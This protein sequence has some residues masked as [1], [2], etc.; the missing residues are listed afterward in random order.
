[1][2][3][4]GDFNGRVSN[5]LARDYIEQD[6][7]NESLDSARYVPDTP[8]L[9]ASVDNVS[10]NHGLQ[11]LDLCKST[12]LRIA[13]GRTDSGK[14]FTYFCRTGSSVID[15]LLLKQDNFGCICD[16][17][18]LEFNE[19]SDHA[20][21]QFALNIGQEK[22]KENKHPS[23]AYS[24]KF[25]WVPEKNIFRRKLIAKLPEINGVFGNID[26]NSAECVNETVLSFVNI[27]NEVAEPCFKQK[28]KDRPRG[29]FKETLYEQAKWFDNECRERKA[30][31]IDAMRLFYSNRTEVDRIM[32]CEKKRIYENT[33]RRK[34]RAF[35]CKKIKTIENLKG[36]Q[37]KDFW[38]LF[39]KAKTES[40]RDITAESFYDYFKNLVDEI[41]IVR[42]EEAE[43]FC[44]N[45]DFS[46]DDSIFEELAATITESEVQA[47]IKKLKRDKSSGSD[48]IINESFLGAG[49][50]LLSHLT[51]LF[52]L[53]LDSGHFPESWSDGII[54]PLFIKGDRT[55]VKIFR[56]ITLVRCLSK[57]FTSVL[58]GRI[59]KWCNAKCKLSDAQFSFR[60]GFST[61]D[62]IYTLHSLIENML[63][64]NKRFYCAF[65]DMKKAFDL[66]TGMLCG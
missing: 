9:R 29:T 42:N 4:C 21:L 34:K 11:L 27:I 39:S 17:C 63:N 51:E 36:K 28:K 53:V 15:Y 6:V 61:T 5:K 59:M 46:G 7:I 3:V 33:V 58:N 47:C 38:K 10:N 35:N 66:Y 49:D 2:I 26:R 57:L 12:S 62:A 14:N 25:T 1:M 48:N 30:K 18:V 32:L 55:D 19:F 52:N 23:T 43:N 50:I 56:G 60:K 54:I 24:D 8:L 44:E 64:N 13:N 37:P 45:N 40:G 65:V 41:N 31:Y 16:F 22:D 20:P